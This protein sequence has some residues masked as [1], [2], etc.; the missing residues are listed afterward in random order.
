MVLRINSST[1]EAESGTRLSS[2]R[3]VNINATAGHAD[4]VIYRNGL[5]WML[6]VKRPE[7]RSRLSASQKR[8]QECCV[9]YG[10]PYG[11][12]CSPSEA[13]Q[14]ITENGGAL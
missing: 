10:V 7:T 4:L 9:R 13:V 12:V 8:F 6:E 3:V 14:F 11:V 1:M 2:Y 5:A